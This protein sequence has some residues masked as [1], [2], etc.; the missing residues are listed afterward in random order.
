MAAIRSSNESKER[1]PAMMTVMIALVVVGLLGYVGWKW[2]AGE[3]DVPTDD[4]GG[5]QV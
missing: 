4:V 1:K 5:D 3:G 2:L